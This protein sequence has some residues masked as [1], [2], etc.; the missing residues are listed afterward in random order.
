MV[1]VLF[2]CLGNIC[3]SPMAEG[4]FQS[5]ILERNFTSK[6]YCDSAGTSAYH[7]G[8]LSDN[9]MRLT[10]QK[11]QINLTHRARQ[12]TPQDFATFDYILAMDKSNLDDI[13][14]LQRRVEMTDQEVLACKVMLIGAFDKHQ[15]DSEVPDPYFGK[16]DGFEEVY[17]ILERCNQSLLDFLVEQHY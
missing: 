17:Q 9:R 4:L 11:H 3:R 15:A 10:A 2:V 6:F 16:M 13:I 14:M 7:L 5:M 8:E 1:K 12:L